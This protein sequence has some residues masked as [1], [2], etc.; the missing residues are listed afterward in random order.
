[1]QAAQ[2]L[3][4]NVL[5]VSAAPDKCV[6]QPMPQ[7]GLRRGGVVFTNV[8][9]GNAFAAPRWLLLNYGAGRMLPPSAAA[10]GKGVARLTR[11]AS[12][13][14]RGVRPA[15]KYN[16]M[17]ESHDVFFQLAW[18]ALLVISLL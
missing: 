2:G 15:V 17:K 9:T 11:G 10:L 16:E 5:R 4:T 3:I 13:A 7:K 8:G 12:T 14:A 6:V 1:M 18:A